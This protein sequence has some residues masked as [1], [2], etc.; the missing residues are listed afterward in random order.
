[1]DNGTFTATA[2]APLAGQIKNRVSPAESAF[3]ACGSGSS[4]YLGVARSASHNSSSI[5][6]T[7]RVQW[8]IG[9]LRWLTTT[10]GAG[11][12]R[13]LTHSLLSVA[14]NSGCP[15][16][17]LSETPWLSTLPNKYCLQLAS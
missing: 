6:R 17:E 5:I 3:S 12:P 13:L 16:R 10:Y 1:M 11:V 8:R 2:H 15:Y 4:V 7:F 9:T 14:G